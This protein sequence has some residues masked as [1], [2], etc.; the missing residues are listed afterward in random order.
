MMQKVF[1]GTKIGVTVIKSNP[2]PKNQADNEMANLA[3]NKTTDD[4]IF[5]N[6]DAINFKNEYMKEGENN[7]NREE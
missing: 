5:S 1:E 7:S 3:E 4:I 6:M 2:P